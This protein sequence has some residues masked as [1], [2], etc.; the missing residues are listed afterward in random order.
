MTERTFLSRYLA[1]D[2]KNVWD[3]LNALGEIVEQHLIIDALAVARETMRRVAIN[4]EIL[5]NR[6]KELGLEFI[7][8]DSAFV[9]VQSKTLQFL[10]DFEKQWGYLPF[11]VRAW[12][13]CIHSVN[14]F[15]SKPISIELFQLID[16][17]VI[18]YSYFD[19]ADLCNQLSPNDDLCW[20]TH[21]IIV[22]SLEESLKKILD[23]KKN[24]IKDWEEEKI[25][26]WT[27]YYYLENN[28]DLKG[29]SLVSLPIGMTMSTCEP[30]SFEV[31]IAKADCVVSDDGVQTTFV[32]LLRQYLLLGGLLYGHCSKNQYYEYLYLGKIPNYYEIESKFLEGLLPF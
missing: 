13:E 2:Y 24:F 19:Y 18:G 20:Y 5:V 4:L 14:M 27:R 11:S 21:N 12:Y 3:E 15:A 10:D 9:L 26:D 6:L 22:L 30:M 28:I 8:I 1:G 31:G 17:N 32:E 16:P 25:D 7:E 29:L 23:L